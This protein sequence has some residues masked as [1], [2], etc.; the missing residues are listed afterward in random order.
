MN[1]RGFLTRVAASLTAAVVAP[2]IIEAE[3]KRFF[4]LDQTMISPRPTRKNYGELPYSIEDVRVYGLNDPIDSL[5]ISFIPDPTLHTGDI[6]G[7]DAT[8]KIAK[9]GWNSGDPIA[10]FGIYDESWGGRAIVSGS[11]YSRQD[12]SFHYI[13]QWITKEPEAI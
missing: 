3:A 9:I 7:L 1:R 6:V 12:P 5:D 10:I 4:A 2:E 8:G 13:T 11:S